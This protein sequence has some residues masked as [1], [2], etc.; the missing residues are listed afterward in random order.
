MQIPEWKQEHTIRELYE[1]AMAI[2]NQEDADQYFE[3]L[4]VHQS[5]FHNMPREE[6]A[7]II[8]SNIGYYAGYFSPE[9]A[10]RM[11]RFFKATH[12]IFGL[13]YAANE[14]TSE[15]AFKAGYEMGKQSQ[16]NAQ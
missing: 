11:Y 15:D 12:P 6:I 2:D 7:P 16:E 10:G 4:L 1:P 14:V 5:A 8:R 3:A 9:V 13:A